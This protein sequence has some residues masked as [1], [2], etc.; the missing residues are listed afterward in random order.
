MYDLSMSAQLSSYDLFVWYLVE[1][2][3]VC[4]FGCRHRVSHDRLRVKVGVVV[5]N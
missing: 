3:R 1:P 4:F 5:L 2:L